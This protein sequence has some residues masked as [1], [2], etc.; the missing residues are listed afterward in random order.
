MLGGMSHADISVV[1]A[2]MSIRIRRH[3]RGLQALSGKRGI[4]GGVFE[5]S[6]GCCE[7]CIPV[8]HGT[9]S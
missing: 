6:A 7:V 1:L 9:E 2:S 8:N 3:M 5:M 4:K